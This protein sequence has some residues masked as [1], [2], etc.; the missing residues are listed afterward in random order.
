[1]LKLKYI[2]LKNIKILIVGEVITWLRLP[3]CSLPLPKRN[4][5]A[6][7]TSASDGNTDYPAS[8]ECDR[9]TDRRRLTA[10][11]RSRSGR[12]TRLVAVH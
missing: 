5:A 11:G 6:L 3:V 7:E 12:R 1:M 10:G 2:I 8:P 4:K 9:P